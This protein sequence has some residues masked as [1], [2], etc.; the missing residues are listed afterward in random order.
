LTN[1]VNNQGLVASTD[2]YTIHFDFI[3]GSGQGVEISVTVTNSPLQ[4]YTILYDSSLKE[5]KDMIK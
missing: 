5:V 4:G 3:D 2:D 1:Q